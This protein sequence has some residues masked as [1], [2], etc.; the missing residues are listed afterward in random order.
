MPPRP[1]AQHVAKLP[2]LLAA[3]ASDLRQGF[4]EPAVHG[5]YYAC[6]HAALALLSTAGLAPGTHRGVQEMLSLHFVLPGHLPRHF[7]RLFGQLRG[8]RE[9]AD[10]GVAGDLDG[11]AARDHAA[12]ALEFLDAVL[13]LL[14]NLAPE[15]AAR[16]PDLQPLRRLL[17]GQS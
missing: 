14:G 16:A 4:A 6:F 3:A 15:A 1:P 10:Y 9:I 13:P 11:P 2:V 12:K 17:A 7:G 8:D 5:L